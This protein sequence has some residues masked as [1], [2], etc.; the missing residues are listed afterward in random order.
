MASRKRGAS[1]PSR[2]SA[3]AEASRGYPAEPSVY[4]LE[5]SA[6]LAALLEDDARLLAILRT[7]ARLVSSALT[8]AECGRGLVR[9]RAASRL[10]SDA[11]QRARAALIALWQRCE[12]IPVSD[13]VL[14][15]AGRP[16]PTEPV[17]SLDAIHLASLEQL[18]AIRA[19]VIVLTRDR[20]VHEN[21]LQL[22]FMVA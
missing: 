14:E 12:S 8:L 2:R 22:G 10:S 3:V 19:D 20:R 7:S 9:A 17:R 21:A 18:G 1:T 16:F 6:L 15:R 5:S 13:V 11:E 4:Y